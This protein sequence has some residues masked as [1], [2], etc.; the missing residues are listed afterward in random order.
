MR[1]IATDVAWSLFV[2]VSVERNR[3]PYKADESI[4]MPFAIWTRVGHKQ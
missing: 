1:P 3:E 2:C 4:K